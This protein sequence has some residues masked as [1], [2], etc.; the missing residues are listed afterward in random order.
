[1]IIFAFVMSFLLI[2]LAGAHG[3]LI[4]ERR[5]NGRMIQRRQYFWVAFDTILGLYWLTVLTGSASCQL[6]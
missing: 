3:S 1:M 5:R 4:L 6:F 2:A